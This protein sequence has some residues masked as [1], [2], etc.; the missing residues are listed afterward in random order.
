MVV[1]AFAPL[2]LFNISIFYLLGE[3]NYKKILLQDCNN[4]AINCFDPVLTTL[5]GNTLTA[6]TVVVRANML[7]SGSMDHL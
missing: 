1:L 7:Y 2:S 4:A 3:I 6:V 5:E